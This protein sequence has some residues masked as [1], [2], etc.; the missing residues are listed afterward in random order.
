MNN[1]LSKILLVLALFIATL[2]TTVN[3][4]AA[5]SNWTVLDTWSTVDINAIEKRTVYSNKTI[6]KTVTTTNSAGNTVITTYNSV[7]TVKT[8]SWVEQTTTI[9]YERA[10]AYGRERVF[11]GKPSNIQVPKSSSIEYWARDVLVNTEVIVT[12]PS[13]EELEAQRLAALAEE[14]ARLAEIARL[15]AEE[16]ARLLAIAEEE[17]RAELARIAEEERLAEEARLLAIAEEARVAEEERLAALAEE[18]RLAEE[19]RL[20]AIAEEEAEALRLAEELALAEAEAPAT[21]D[22]GDNSIYLGTPTEMPSSDPTYYQGLSNF[23]D[24]NSIVGQDWALSRGW[25][26]KGSTIGILD[27]GVDIDHPEL[28]GKVKYQ[29]EPGYD[30]GIED[31]VGHGSHV[32][33]IAAGNMGGDVMGI[34]PDANLAIVKITDSWSA[35]MSFARQ[36]ITYL[37]NNTDAV[38]ANLSANTNYHSSYTSSVTNRGNGVFTS[39][40]IHYGGSNYYN[41]ETPDSWGSAMSGSEIVLTI[42]A[43]NQSNTFGATDLSEAALESGLIQISK[44]KD[45]RGIL[46]GLQAKSLHVPSDLAFT[47]D[48]ILNSTMSTTIGVNPTTA[49]NGATN[50]ND[51]N[52][53]RNQ[54]LIPG[55]FFVNRRF[56]DTDAWFIK[57]DC[58]NG[59]KMFVRAPLQT[60]MEPDFDTGNLRFK[61]RERYS[62]GWSDWRGFYGSS[63]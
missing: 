13:E 28:V 25:T 22:F 31:S 54:G 7:F 35:S 19:A 17:A 16:E 4:N 36:G 23:K 49:A 51:I 40:H 52:S 56:T 12:G 44:A 41:M 29:W 6:P 47:A 8:D 30:N 32:A 15:E 5:P 34:A 18:E 63:G 1:T 62:F 37:K 11:R 57:T 14:E 42:S 53:I 58:P 50:V 46:I 26:G 20:L 33:S 45:D 9:V 27:S 21:L 59:A 48:Q 61:A 55:G 24:H 10:T 3:A 43:G 39:N 60:K 38:V 2:V